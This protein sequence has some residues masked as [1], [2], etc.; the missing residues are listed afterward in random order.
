[1]SES[2]AGK[3]GTPEV[4][5][6]LQYCAA[7]VLSVQSEVAVKT[8]IDESLR[9]FHNKVCFTFNFTTAK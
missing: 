5:E 4:D 1:M 6:E 3:L 8:V 7:V 2:L 9:L